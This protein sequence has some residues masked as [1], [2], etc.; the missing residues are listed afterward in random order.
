MVIIFSGLDAMELLCE[1]CNTTRQTFEQEFIQSL[2]GAGVWEEGN[3]VPE[4]VAITAGST[5]VDAVVVYPPDTVIE[6]AIYRQLYES[7]GTIFTPD[8]MPSVAGMLGD[9]FSQDVMY[10]GA[11]PAGASALD[12]EAPHSSGMLPLYPGEKAVVARTVGD[13]VKCKMVWFPQYLCAVLDMWESPP[14]ETLETISGC[15]GEEGFLTFAQPKFNSAFPRQ[16]AMSCRSTDVRG[17]MNIE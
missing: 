4:V 1:T 14:A 16:F 11:T 10:T 8:T 2:K 7:P 6:S 5:V 17:R 13:H 12:D 9:V 15:L 3:G